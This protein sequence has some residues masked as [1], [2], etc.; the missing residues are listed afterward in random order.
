MQAGD[1]ALTD[2]PAGE[3]ARIVL[4]WLVALAFLAAGVLHVRNPAPFLKITP[5]WVPFPEQVILLTGLCEIAGAIGLFVPRLRRLSGIMLALYSVCVFPANIHHALAHVAVG[6]STLG[7]GY[8][9][10][11]L[12]VQPVIV[13][14]CLFAGGAIDWPWR[15]VGRKLS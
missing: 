13:W 15:S 2:C 11:R 9:G 1:M 6:G 8:H 4:R 3:R 14:W 12:A 10:P 7:W 5:D